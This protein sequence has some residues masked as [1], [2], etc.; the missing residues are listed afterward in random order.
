MREK[1]KQFMN[2]KQFHICVIICII[3]II[4]FVVGVISIKYSVEGEANP[5]FF[6]KKISIIS[7]VE[8][9]NNEDNENR[10]NLAVDQNNDIYLYIAKNESYSQTEIIQSVIIENFQ[11]LKE[12]TIGIGKIYKPDS[13]IDTTLFRNS[14]E[15][16]SEKIE[17]KGSL[18]TDIKNLEISNQGD[19]VIFRYAITNVGQYISN[20]DEEINHSQLLN[21]LNVDNDNLKTKITFDVS[22]KLESEKVYKANVQ[23]EL[24]I[25]D[26]VNGGI[27]SI[28]ITDLNDI[29][30]KR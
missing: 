10:W 15:N 18:E 9:T 4:L 22:I 3:F 21:K 23:L 26:V 13:G 1:V 19:K 14:D 7:C 12:P 20:E 30:F 29:I 8:G 24:P 27:Q 11:V 6:I 5:P 17:Y 16:I 28:D 25:N 2:T